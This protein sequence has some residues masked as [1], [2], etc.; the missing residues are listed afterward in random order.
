M[1]SAEMFKSKKKKNNILYVKVVRGQQPATC[2][3]KNEA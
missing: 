2:L 3:E 1:Q